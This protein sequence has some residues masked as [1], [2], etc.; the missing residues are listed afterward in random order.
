MYLTVHAALGGAIGQFIGEPWLAFVIGFAS[1]LLSDAIP[2]GDE[3]IIKWKLFKT[4]TGRMA[5]A[6]LIDFMIL[7]GMGLYWIAATPWPQLPGLVFGMAGGMAPDMLWGFHQLT[8]APFL[9]WYRNFHGR[10]H[11][12]F[13]H[14]HLTIIQGLAVQI[15]LLLVLTGVI[16][17]F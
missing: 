1:H 5:A 4:D 14:R 8:Q 10:F 12:V 17:E 15:P 16:I 13:T 2:H 3:D 6:A 11:Y 9:N 7:C